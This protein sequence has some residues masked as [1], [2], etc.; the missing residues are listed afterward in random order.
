MIQYRELQSREDLEGMQAL[1]RIIWDMEPIPLHQTMTAIKHGG[2]IVGAFDREDLIG[3]SYGFA[4]FSDGK[5]Y[6]CSHMLGVHPDYQS[7][8][9]GEALKY[10]Q[11]TFAA[12][13]GF[14]HMVWTYDPL[15]AR[16]GYLNLTKLGAVSFKYLENCY[17]EMTDGLNAGL[18]SDRFE[19]HWPTTASR[20]EIDFSEPESLADIVWVNEMPLLT[21]IRKVGHA[22]SYAVPI[23]KDFQALKKQD[24]KLAIQWRLDSRKL[25]QE[26]VA[27]DYC[28]IELKQDRDWH[29]YIFLKKSEVYYGGTA[30]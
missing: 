14:T 10:H 7:K 26:L 20:S 18:P 19:V 13:R 30:L 11:Q 24:P 21:N 15:E 22:Q 6:L 9:V 29:S 4:G 12:K 27:N 25:F 5:A 16:N 2:V 28:A 1:E 3:F 17:G 8:K 23:P